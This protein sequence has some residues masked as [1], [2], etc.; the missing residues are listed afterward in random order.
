MSQKFQAAVHHRDDVSYVKLSGVIDEDNELTD[1]TDF[2][3]FWYQLQQDGLTLLLVEHDMRLV[4]GIAD[5]VLVMNHGEKIAEGTPAQV[6]RDE[7]V[8]SAYLGEEVVSA[9]G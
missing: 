9:A 5:E 6:Q 1:L 4:M 8:L 3:A 2:F 7:A